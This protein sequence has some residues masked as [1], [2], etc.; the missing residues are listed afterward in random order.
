MPRAGIRPAVA[1]ACRRPSDGRS[2]HPDDPPRPSSDDPRRCIVTSAAR[3]QA[4]PD[5][6]PIRKARPL[7]VAVRVAARAA[8]MKGPRLGCVVVMATYVQADGTWDRLS[9]RRFAIETGFSRATVVHTIRD[10]KAA[11]ILGIERRSGRR[12]AGTWTFRVDRLPIHSVDRVPI[13]LE[14]HVPTHVQARAAFKAAGVLRSG[15]R[16]PDQ[17]VPDLESGPVVSEART[18]FE[19]APA[20]D[21]VQVDFDG[22]AALRLEVR[23]NRE[24]LGLAEPTPMPTTDGRAVYQEAS[25]P[26]EPAPP[27]LPLTSDVLPADGCP[28]CERE[29][30]VAL[31]D[32]GRYCGGC[33]HGFP[34]PPVSAARRERER[35]R[36]ER[37][38][39][40]AEERRRKARRYRLRS[41]LN[42]EGHVVEDVETVNPELMVSEVCPHCG[43]ATQDDCMKHACSGRGSG[44]YRPSADWNKGGDP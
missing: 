13:H 4:Q 30:W 19:A 41:A 42:P 28:K 44:E 27:P 17:G 43:G 18:P 31:P 29:R 11:G 3:A 15:T 24:S 8:G 2:Y 26:A 33:G 9:S 16:D 1:E 25:P 34:V 22:R 40:E 21:P 35:L 12:R 23:A 36:D 39:A 14:T 37:E 38:Q 7:P 32:G 6:T 5:D 20:S 10:A